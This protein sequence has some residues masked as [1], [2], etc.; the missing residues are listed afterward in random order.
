MAYLEQNLCETKRKYQQK[1]TLIIKRQ[2]K[3]LNHE[4]N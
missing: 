1:A 3:Q 4:V 2:A